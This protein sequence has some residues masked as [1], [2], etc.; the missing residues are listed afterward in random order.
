LSK[1]L[2][3]YAW[4]CGA[5]VF[6]VAAGFAAG[7]DRFPGDLRVAQWIQDVD[8]F[9]P[10]ADFA[11]FAGDTLPSAL[12]ALG[13]IVVLVFRRSPAA[14]LVLLTFPL[15]GGRW[16]VAELVARPRP[17]A[18]LLDIRDT[19][20]GFSFP[21]GHTAGAVLLWGALFCVSERLVPQIVARRLL[22][23]FCLFVVAIT[24]PARVY[25]GVH[26]PSDVLGGYLFG[27][28]ALAPLVV[29]YR[30]ASQC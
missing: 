30:R 20:A 2:L 5:V 15:R 24:G 4:L 19:A 6:V 11:N 7:N 14:A 26:W 3:L 29:L 13:F 27:L 18:D 28:L 17:S 9:A 22:Q 21:S 1:K 10:F 23:A 12:I 25:V 16:L 8:I